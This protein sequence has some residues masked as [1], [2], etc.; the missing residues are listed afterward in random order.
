[1]LTETTIGRLEALRLLRRLDGA[2]KPLP[3]IARYALAISAKEESE[4]GELS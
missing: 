3:A 1:V 4:T 2:V